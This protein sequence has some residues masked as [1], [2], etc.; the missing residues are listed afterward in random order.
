MFKDLVGQ[1]FGTQSFKRNTVFLQVR[2]PAQYTKAQGTVSFGKAVRSSQVIIVF[3]FYD[4]LLQYRIQEEDRHFYRLRIFPFIVQ[5]Q[6]HGRQAADKGFV[7]RR[8]QGNLR[9][10]VTGI[11]LQAQVFVHL[12]LI[13]VY[14]IREEQVWQ[15]FLLARFQDLSPDFT[16]LHIA[17]NHFLHPVIRDTYREEQVLDRVANV[18][19]V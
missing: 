7:N 12:R 11:D 15:A 5:F 14:I 16:L 8:R 3:C 10:K 6:V 19:D 2:V 1:L 9:T 18:L 4:K 13:T 17:V